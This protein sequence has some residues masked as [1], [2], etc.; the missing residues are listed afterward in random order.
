MII[1]VVVTKFD[2]YL[3]MIG[4]LLMGGLYVYTPLSLW[5]PINQIEIFTHL[6]LW[7]KWVKITHFCFNL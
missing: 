1:Q 7:L 3:V 5:S 4:C 6:K 2:S